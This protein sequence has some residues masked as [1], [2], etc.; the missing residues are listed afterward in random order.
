MINLIQKYNV[1]IH[2]NYCH[3][4]CMC[5][6]FHAI[7]IVH[8]MYIFSEPCPSALFQKMISEQLLSTEEHEYATK[9]IDSVLNQLNWAFSEFVGML[10]E[11]RIHSYQKWHR[12]CDIV[13]SWSTHT[14]WCTFWW[15]YCV[16]YQLGHKYNDTIYYTGFYVCFKLTSK[17]V[18]L[19]GKIDVVVQCCC[20][21]KDDI[22]IQKH[23]KT[24]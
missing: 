6:H 22:A 21:C 8:L 16:R 13:C 12:Q 24:V 2:G 9:F 3:F 18:H 11:V 23:L 1:R 17:S 4:S 7:R 20:I 10:Q 14:H 15:H 5:C 19:S